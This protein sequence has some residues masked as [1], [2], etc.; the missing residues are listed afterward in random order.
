M[1]RYFIRAVLL[2]FLF[3]LGCVLNVAFAQTE[4]HYVGKKE[5][6]YGIAKKYNTTEETLLKLNPELRNRTLRSG[7]FI[8]VPSLKSTSKTPPLSLL[9]HRIKPGETLTAIAKIYGVSIDDILK[10]NPEITRD[11][12]NAGFILLIPDTGKVKDADRVP[13]TVDRSENASAVSEKPSSGSEYSANQFYDSDTVRVSIVLPLVEGSNDRYLHF[14]EGFLMGLNDLKK[15]NIS[16]ILHTYNVDGVS[17]AKRLIQSGSL[18]GE[19]VLIGGSSDDE[20]D[21]FANFCRDRNIN[22]VV[23]FSSRISDDAAYSTLFKINPLQET[24]YPY[25]AKEF[26]RRYSGSVIYFV[27]SSGHQDSFATYLQN[28]L[29][30]ADVSY[31]IKS[32]DMLDKSADGAVVVPMSPRE[33]VLRKLLDRLDGEEISCKLFGYP[34]WQSFSRS[35]KNRMIKYNATFYSSFYFP[36]GTKEANIFLNKFYA[37]FSHKVTDTYP[38]Y[39]VLGYDIAKYFVSAI[40]SGGMYFYKDKSELVSSGLQSSFRFVQPNGTTLHVNA[41][42]FFVTPRSSGPAIREAIVNPK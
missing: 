35:T 31:R 3:S 20:I 6:V 40:H 17:D 19:H 21:L 29:S 41:N 27:G 28:A 14:L 25:I 7:E 32:V 26:I 37:W 11:S 18:Y 2:T 15:Q 5:T 42:V 8:M 9:K 38:K 24:L 34:Q 16:V 30:A 23:P 39:S 36:L 13:Q 10:L 4:K 22:Y 12:Y 33:S 1:N